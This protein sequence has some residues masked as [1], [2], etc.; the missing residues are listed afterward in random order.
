MRRLFEFKKV[1]FTKNYDNF[2]TA[3]NLREICWDFIYV[4]YELYCS[5]KDNY[6]RLKKQIMKIF[7]KAQKVTRT[8]KQRL[9]TSDEPGNYIAVKSVT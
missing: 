4:P 9:S 7:E 1:S 6:E 5:V 2:D 8:I 3:G